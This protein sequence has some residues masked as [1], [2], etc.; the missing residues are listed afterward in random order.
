MTFQEKDA[1]TKWCPH[2]NAAA[3]H[4][5]G[6]RQGTTHC[7]GA[8]CAIWCW[9]DQAAGVGGCAVALAASRPAAPIGGPAVG[10]IAREDQ[11]SLGA[12]TRN[13]KRP[14]R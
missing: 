14:R 11:S 6:F 7:L 5:D 3:A 9:A 13:G 4:I 2:S 12:M 8:A 10:G 1:K